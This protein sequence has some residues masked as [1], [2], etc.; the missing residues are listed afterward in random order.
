MG[1][2][3]LKSGTLLAPLPAVMVTTG[4]MDEPNIIT[5]GWVGILSSEPPRTYISVRPS[6]HSYK[7]LKENGEFVI[8]LTNEKTAHATDYAGIYTGAKV[9]K[10]EKLG[11]TAISSETVAP[12]TIKEC[13]LALECR[14]FKV[15]ESGTHDIFMADILNVSCDD[16]LI[17]ENGKICLDK[18]GLIAY[19]HGEYFTLGEKIGKFGFSAAKGTKNAGK[20][21]KKPPRESKKAVA[22]AKLKA[23]SRTS[24]QQN[25]KSKPRA[26]KAFHGAGVRKKQSGSGRKGV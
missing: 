22:D 23:P 7:A 20:S 5:I 4:T 12:P 1:R 26:K 9:N 13:P 17:D 18:G 19:A 10:F 3:N 6:R 14:V 24:G 11:L 15:I 8:N 25:K 2:S 16:A 21:G